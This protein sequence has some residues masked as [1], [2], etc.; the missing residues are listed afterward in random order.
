MKIIDATCPLVYEIHQEVTKLAKD[1]RKIIVIGDHGH[2]EVIAIANQVKNSIVISSTEEALNLKKMKKAGVVSQSTQAIKN[3]Q[4]IINILMT[5]V[6]DLHFVNTICFPT[7]RNHD[8]IK[9]MARLN[10]VMIIIGS[11]TSANSNR[12]T[13]LS[14]DF[15]PQS[16]QVTDSED[17]KSEWFMDKDKV[18]ISA[19]AST[20]DYLIK[21][22]KDNIEKIYKEEL[23]NKEPSKLK[24]A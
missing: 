4:K 2:D 1:G 18:G 19:G 10:D 15:N 16:Y 13:K 5:K 9:E 22:V 11:F 3:V 24:L 23:W 12:L 14:L 17:L 21:D 6:F 7:K 8:Q 20:P